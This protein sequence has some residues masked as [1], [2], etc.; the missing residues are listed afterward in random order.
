MM[1][2][3][4]VI[5]WFVFRFATAISREAV[6]STQSNSSACSNGPQDRQCWGEFDINTNYYEVTPVTGNTVEVITLFTYFMLK[7]LVLFDG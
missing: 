3:A 5:L 2:L 7:Q 6:N 4:L 1:K